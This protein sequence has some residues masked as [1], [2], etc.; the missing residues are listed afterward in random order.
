MCEGGTR[1]HRSATKGAAAPPHAVEAAEGSEQAYDPSHG[2][3][4]SEISLGG[5]LGGGQRRRLPSEL[6]GRLE[7]TWWR[8]D[9]GL[10]LRLGIKLDLISG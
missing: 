9:V 6:V 2:T 4:V 7:Y 3:K 1:S 10:D 8:V 5:H